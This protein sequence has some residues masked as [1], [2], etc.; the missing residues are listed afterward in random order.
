M[1]AGYPQYVDKSDMLKT[2]AIA[3]CSAT[4]YLAIIIGLTAYCS[5]HQVRAR[6]V[7]KNVHTVSIEGTLLNK[8]TDK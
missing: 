7:L 3:V 5:I 8:E 2:I 1:R 6:N 4:V